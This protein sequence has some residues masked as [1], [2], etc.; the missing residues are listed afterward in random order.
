M[1]FYYRDING[2]TGIVKDVDTLPSNI[3]KLII[4]RYNGDYIRIP[5]VDE[6]ILDCNRGKIYG[7]LFKCD[8]LSIYKPNIDWFCINNVWISDDVGL[9]STFNTLS[10]LKLEH[11]ID[12]NSMLKNTLCSNITTVLDFSNIEIPRITH[13]IVLVPMFHNTRLTTIPKIISNPELSY[14]DIFDGT[15]IH[16]D[17]LKTA[18]VLVAISKKG[19]AS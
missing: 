15:L 11:V 2:K 1:K 3:E 6:L 8:R 10:R 18:D 19:E 13:S 5:Y 17:K 4:R 16:E 9:T 12:A 7:I 14:T